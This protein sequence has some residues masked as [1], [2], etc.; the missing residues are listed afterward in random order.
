MAVG[1]VITNGASFSDSESAKVPDAG[2]ILRSAS[3]CSS[4]QALA[5]GKSDKTKSATHAMW[6]LDELDNLEVKI[7][8]PLKALR[9]D[10]GSGSLMDRPLDG[11]TF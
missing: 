6:G 1:V 3:G 4:D 8:N 2:T 10:W 7:T 5:C 11:E 9:F